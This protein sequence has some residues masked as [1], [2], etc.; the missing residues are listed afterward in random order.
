M[1][2]LAVVLVVLVALAYAGHWVATSNH[3]GIEFTRVIVRI[4]LVMVLL[5]CNLALFT[6]HFVRAEVRQW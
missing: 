3:P 1:A 4:L 2:V 6:I 5:V